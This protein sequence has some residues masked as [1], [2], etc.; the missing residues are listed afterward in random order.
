MFTRRTCHGDG[1]AT[2]PRSHGGGGK[3]LFDFARRLTEHLLEVAFGL[4]RLLLKVDVLHYCYKFVSCDFD[5]LVFDTR[6]CN[7]KA[8]GRK[9]K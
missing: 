7:I 1:G 6:F 4:I 3:S 9:T 5:Q 2:D 8:G